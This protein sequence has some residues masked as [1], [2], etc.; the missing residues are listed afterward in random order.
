LKRTFNNIPLQ[1]FS[2]FDIKE[3]VNE[4]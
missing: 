4:K 2:A 1:S 3:K